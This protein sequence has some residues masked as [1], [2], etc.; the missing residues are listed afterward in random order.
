MITGIGQDLRFVVNLQ[1]IHLAVAHK[2]GT[3]ADFHTFLC[4]LARFLCGARV[5]PATGGIR[6]EAGHSVLDH[7]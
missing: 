4:A 3:P 5:I 2:N 6:D 7:D 1:H